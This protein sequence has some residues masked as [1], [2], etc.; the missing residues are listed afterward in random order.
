MYRIQ[1]A[2]L[3]ES[4]PRAPTARSGILSP[5]RSPKEVTKHPKLSPATSEPDGS[6]DASVLWSI[7]LTPFTLPSAFIYRIQ[8]VPGLEKV[9]TARS[10]ISSPSRSPEEVTEDP[11]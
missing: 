6:A 9:P 8:A 2:P 10:G 11:K 3:A 1:I 7:F 4:V 5:S